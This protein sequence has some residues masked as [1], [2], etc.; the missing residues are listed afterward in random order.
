M[1]QHVG[2]FSKLKKLFL[3][4]SNKNP[5]S[6]GAAAGNE[7]TKFFHGMLRGRLKRNAIK[8]LNVNG[9]WVEDPPTLKHHIADFFKKL[10]QEQDLHRPSFTSNRF[11]LLTTEQMSFLDALFFEEE[12]K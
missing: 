8:G 9:P 7:N 11:K 3:N 2:A 5:G 4:P 10:F 1:L 6:R 12:I